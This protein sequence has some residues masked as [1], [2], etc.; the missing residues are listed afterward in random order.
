MGKYLVILIC[1]YFVFIS[2]EDG[3]KEKVKDEKVEK[4]KD[5]RKPSGKK[6]SIDEKGDIGITIRFEM[7]QI[8]DKVVT[9][10]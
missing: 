8:I 3:K 1:L 6:I 4:V 7:L 9:Q 2:A 10:A 5:G